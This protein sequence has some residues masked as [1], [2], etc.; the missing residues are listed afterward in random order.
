MNTLLVIFL[1]VGMAL[2]AVGLYEMQAWLERWDYDRHAQ[3]YSVRAIDIRG[4]S[5]R[6]TTVIER[7]ASEWLAPRRSL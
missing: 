3:D 2:M 6:A 7:A 5:R 1:T 4:S